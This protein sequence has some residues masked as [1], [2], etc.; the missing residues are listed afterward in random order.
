MQEEN[1][2]NYKWVVIGY[3]TLQDGGADT[4]PLN[5]LNER[6]NAG[7]LLELGGN[8]PESKRGARGGKGEY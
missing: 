5:A 8:W 7:F 1:G 6:E 2:A 4:Y 3:G